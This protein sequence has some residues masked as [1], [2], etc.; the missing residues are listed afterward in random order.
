MQ[1]LVLVE[2]LPQ[3]LEQESPGATSMSMAPVLVLPMWLISV[4]ID[5]LPDCGCPQYSRHGSGVATIRPRGGRLRCT[6]S[7]AQTT[8]ATQAGSLLSKPVLV[9]LR[10]WRV[11][12]RVTRGAVSGRPPARSARVVSAGTCDWRRAVP[13][14]KQWPS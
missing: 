7:F 13:E 6:G 10:D 11:R 2:V 3:L 1:L 8:G 5:C 9:V 12:Q 4:S 14:V